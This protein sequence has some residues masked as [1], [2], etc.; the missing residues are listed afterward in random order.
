MMEKVY[1]RPSGI[2]EGAVT[3]FC[4]GCMHSSVCK[5]VTEA[6]DELGMVDN[7]C[8]VQGVGCCGLAVTYFDFDTVAAPHGRACA[9][10]SSFKRC[11]PETLVFTYQ[12]D[13]DLAAIGLAETMSAA[14]RGE[15]FTV[16]F[17]NN[18]IYGMT[19][20]QMAPTTLVGMKATTAPFGRDPKEHGYPMHVCEILNQLTAP[21]YLERT[22]CNNP[23]NVNKT[24]AAIKKAFQN[25]L[26]GKG[27][28]LVE[29]VTS[30]PTN[31]GLDALDALDYLEDKM[32]AE[33]PLG[34][35]RDKSKEEA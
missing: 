6:L 29:I 25:Q 7:A 13:G 22:S 4:P 3:G 9:I 8:Y 21:Y 23:A 34:V 24:K 28:S 1:S 33:F 31:W 19:G 12:G 18:G 2:F 30:C 15:N 20:G 32:F 5:I 11:S 10:A 14:N 26:D 17:V 35:I 16:I 27:F